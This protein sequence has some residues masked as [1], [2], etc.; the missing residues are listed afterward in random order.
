[1]YKGMYVATEQDI[2]NLFFNGKIYHVKKHR[3]DGGRFHHS[4]WNFWIWV[5]WYFGLEAFID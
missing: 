4:K 2:L 1:M 5:A 3:L